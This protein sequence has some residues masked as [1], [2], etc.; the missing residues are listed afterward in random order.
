MIIVMRLSPAL[1]IIACLDAGVPLAAQP[2]SAPMRE[3]NVTT[4]SAPGWLPSEAEERAARGALDRYFAAIAA[5]DDRG[6][7]AMMTPGQ[8]AIMSFAEFV[9]ANAG[10]RTQAGG[11]RHRRVLRLTWTKDPAD[12]PRPGIYAAFDL[13]ATWTNIDRECGYAILYQEAEG[14]P[15]QLG[16]I[17]SNFIGNDEEARGIERMQGR[18]GLD[19]AWAALTQRCPNYRP[20]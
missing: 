6:A 5:G 7:Y 13:S 2:A 4:D 18:A 3:V 8:Q 16:R 17:E 12:A 1:L 15:F 14:A 10:F 19:Q 9:A 11:L 20:E